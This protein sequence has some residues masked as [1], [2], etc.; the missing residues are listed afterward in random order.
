MPRHDLLD[1]DLFHANPA[2]GD[3][4]VQRFSL[5][6]S[7]TAGRQRMEGRQIKG[8]ENRRRRPGSRVTRASSAG[9]RRSSPPIVTSRRPSSIP[10]LTPLEPVIESRSELQPGSSAE[11]AGRPPGASAA[12]DACLKFPHLCVLK[13]DRTVEFLFATTRQQAQSQKISFTGDRLPTRTVCRAGPDSDHHLP[14]EIKLPKPVSLW[15]YTLWSGRRTSPGILSSRACSSSTRTPGE[16]SSDKGSRT[17][18]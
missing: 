9:H 7:G 15:G 17:K 13:D 4:G 11:P 3:C 1:A 5:G 12:P 16:S 10:S 8:G 2:R 6:R 18:P 14:G